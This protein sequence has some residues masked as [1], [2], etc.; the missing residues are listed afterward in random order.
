MKK[1]I[2]SIV[3]GATVLLF[4]T[5][6]IAQVKIGTGGSKGT[7]YAMAQDMIKVCGSKV[8][9]TVEETDGSM[10]N[11]QG[12]LNKNFQAGIVQ[13]DVMKYLEEKD[14]GM[15]Q[16]KVLFPLH[17]EEVHIIGA[18]TTYKEGGYSIGGFNIGGKAVEL[19]ALKDLNNRKIVAWG[20]SVLSAEYF[21]YKFKLNYEVI[22]V[23]GQKLDD[24][25]NAIKVEKGAEPE[26]VAAKMVANGEAHAIFAVGGFP[27]KWLQDQKVF[28]KQFKLLSIGSEMADQVSGIYNK[29]KVT[30]L[31]LTDGAAQTVAVPAV[32]ATRDY[33]GVDRALP[34]AK[35][36][37]C[38][39]ENLI[40]LR[41]E[42]HQKWSIVD[43][44]AKFERW[45]NYEPP[46]EVMASITPQSAAAKP[47]KKK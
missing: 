13:F 32:V 27:I 7:Y 18:N 2:N 29:A 22:D 23:T 5:S 21:A 47:A 6:A 37:Q 8:T 19:K 40:T 38:V 16:I 45:A 3:I 31:N 17:Q 33:R 11:M 1:L 10:A 14:P 41:D 25:G 20:G 12:I 36:K 39:G 28:G 35:L 34:L 15:S 26:K 24:K 4:A 42:G 44:N 9:L 43:S 46:A 30:Y